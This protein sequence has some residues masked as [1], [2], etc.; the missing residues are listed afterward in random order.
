VQQADLLGR[1]DHIKNS[2]LKQ[3]YEIQSEIQLAQFAG[4][5]DRGS[6][7]NYAERY[8]RI[9]TFLTEDLSEAYSALFS[10]SK[11]VQRVLGIS[12]V[13]IIVRSDDQNHSPAKRLIDVDIPEFEIEEDVEAW[14][15]KI[16]P[17]NVSDPRK[18]DVVD[19]MI[20]WCRAVMRELDRRARYET[21]FTLSIPLSQPIAPTN[22][23]IVDVRSCIQNS[24]GSETYRIPFTLS[25]NQL[26]M[27]GLPSDLRVLGIGLSFLHDMSDYLPVQFADPWDHAEIPIPVQG[28]G[29]RNPEPTVFQIRDARITMRLRTSRINATLTTPKQRGIASDYARPK[30]YL[31]NVRMEGGLDGDIETPLSYDPAC[32]NLSPFGEWRIDISQTAV[33]NETDATVPFPTEWIAGLV[34]HLRVRGT[35]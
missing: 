3:Q 10:A 1:K 21:E 13:S 23:P 19:A 28:A 26:P 18:P 22:M 24:K 29:I 15:R 35:T 34:L 31:S 30:V 12:Q 2:L 8:L 20:V 14:V 11:G 25:Q 32:R 9:L 5:L 17:V 33:T 4:I 27:P 7:S 6:A 16:L